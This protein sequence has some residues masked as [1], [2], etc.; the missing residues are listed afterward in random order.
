MS[1]SIPIPQQPKT[2]WT[3]RVIPKDLDFS[4]FN[5]ER[6]PLYALPP[7]RAAVDKVK[8]EENEFV[9]LKRIEQVHK[10]V[11][12]H[13][14]ILVWRDQFVE[15]S[16]GIKKAIGG[17]LHA[18]GLPTDCLKGNGQLLACLRIIYATH[19]GFNLEGYYAPIK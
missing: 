4:N 2:R 15:P 18:K 8:F 19:Q 5:W 17:F 14:H 11:D 12:N 9:I 10:F 7:L 13:I 3:A 16:P 6:A 1:Y